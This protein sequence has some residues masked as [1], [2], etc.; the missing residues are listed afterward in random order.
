M[1]EVTRIPKSFSFA[2]IVH[3]RD[4]SVRITDDR[5]FYAVDLVMVVNGLARDQ[6]GE[7]FQITCVDQV[8][9]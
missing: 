6:A 5:Y 1:T 7:F 3:G 8:D 9:R 4:A 2:D